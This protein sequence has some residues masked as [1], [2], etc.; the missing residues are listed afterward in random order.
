MVTSEERNL[1]MK[2]DNAVRTIWA[3][4]LMD[5][6][7]DRSA[8][9]EK[10]LKFPSEAGVP[11]AMKLMGDL[12]AAGIGVEKDSVQAFSWYKKAADAGLS[13]GQ[14]RL[15]FCYHY[16]IGTESNL[17]LA[18]EWYT[19]AADQG[20]LEAM[21]ELATIFLSGEDG[22]EK[23]E[24]KGV[25]L[26]RA[27]ADGGH[28]KAQCSLGGLL[29]NPDLMGVSC[30]RQDIA[31]GVKWIQESA[32][33][34]VGTA[35]FLLATLYV[36]GIGVDKNLDEAK[37]MYKRA[38]KHGDL[39]DG[40]EENAKEKL[41]NLGSSPDDADALNDDCSSMDEGAE[42]RNDSDC[43]YGSVKFGPN[44]SDLDKEACRKIYAEV[45]TGA[46]GAEYEMGNILSN[47]MYGIC[48]DKKEA[49]DWYLKSAEHGFAEAQYVVARF[50]S[51]GEKDVVDCN[52]AE[53]FK[54]YWEAAVQGHDE[55][56]LRVADCFY[57]GSGID[58]N[59][60]EAQRWYARAA[61]AGVEGAKSMLK[62]SEGELQEAY[63]IVELVP[64]GLNSHADEEEQEKFRELFKN[65]KDGD[66][67]AQ[68]QLGHAFIYGDDGAKMIEHHGVVW[69]KKAA[70][71]GNADAENLLGDCYRNGWGVSEDVVAAKEWYQKAAEKGHQEA[72]EFLEEWGE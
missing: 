45:T 52:D 11:Q 37:E 65:A 17:P 19:K 32:N 35:E 58:S 30:V 54:W 53:K 61:R 21:N 43:L 26:L 72:K 51:L 10:W 18:V 67:V 50:Y 14:Y 31:A 63:R 56:M 36:Q 24:E 33:Q 47:G 29:L 40:M 66:A 44:V 70:A 34:F 59:K 60:E 1:I 64:P 68:F 9:A 55:S 46:P 22:V 2:I 49:F 7:E 4:N 62:M 27:A 23:N 12:C 69:L 6:I 28:G 5:Q 71:Q 20:D 8:E 41:T 39:L 25:E 3:E 16:A 57:F 13:T 48:V 15:G 38:L 42:S